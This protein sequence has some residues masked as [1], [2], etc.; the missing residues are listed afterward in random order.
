MSEPPSV[1]P[2]LEPKSMVKPS[3]DSVARASI[4][5]L[6]TRGPRLVGVDQSSAVDSRLAVQKSRRHVKD[7]DVMSLQDSLASRQGQLISEGKVVAS[8][9]GVKVREHRLGVP[10]SLPPC[11]NVPLVVPLPLLTTLRVPCAFLQSLTAAADCPNEEKLR[12]NATNASHASV[13]I[14]GFIILLLNLN[15]WSS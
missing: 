2:R 11:V 12:V 3:R 5:A 6:L 1:P 10:L 8:G 4:A 13:L 15:R 9:V 14:V 7:T